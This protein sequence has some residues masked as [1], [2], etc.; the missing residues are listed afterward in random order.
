VDKLQDEIKTE[1]KAEEKQ[2]KK[3]ET[4]YDPLKREPK[5]ANADKTQLYELVALANHS[6]PTVRLWS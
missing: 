3:L 1:V 4:L 5:Y 2:I 6:H